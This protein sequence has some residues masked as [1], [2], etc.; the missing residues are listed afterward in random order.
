MASGRRRDRR[1]GGTQAVDD[2]ANGARFV[3]WP[4]AA[5][6]E[7]D[8]RGAMPWTSARMLW[9]LLVP[10]LVLLGLLAWWGIA[11]IEGQIET[12]APA[13]LEDRGIDSSSLTFSAEYRDLDVG[14]TLPRGVVG[15]DIERILEEAEGSG[16]E[17]IRSVT[18]SAVR[19][20]EPLG[21]INVAVTSDGSTIVLTGNVPSD[22]HRDALVAAATGTGLTVI[23]NLAV[24][25][26]R[27]SAEA[28]EDQVAAME[29]IVAVLDTDVESADLSVGDSGPVIGSVRAVDGATEDELRRL[30]P[31]VAVSSPDPLGNLDV[32]ATFDGSRIVL[33]GTV[34]N[35]QHADS[36]L[37]GAA[38]AVGRPSV[39]DNLTVLGLAPAV[40][41]PE[42]KVS[43]MAAILA[44][45]EG[46]ETGEIAL[47]DTD[48]TVNAAVADAALGDRIADAVADSTNIGLR[49]GGEVS[50]I[51][52]ELSLQEEIDALQAELDAL[53]DEIRKNVVFT[54]SSNSLSELASGTLDKVVDA[55]DRYQRPVVEVG[56][57]TDSRGTDSF[58][59]SLSQR[60]AEAVVNY[61]IS[62]GMAAERLNPVG[63]GESDPV[64]PDESEEAY[65]LNRRVE[66]T[67][68]ESF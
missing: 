35:Q 37:A 41:D 56:G 24:S 22:Q 66:F 64:T 9:T 27:A 61:L 55:M 19:F 39:V 12:T 46:A 32:L 34:L 3:S 33:D 2:A 57:H 62:Q 18:V 11:H 28:P 30:G 1:A 51:E 59:L 17:D 65:Q 13:L 45:F 8:G 10:L 5:L 42:V 23:D 25:G 14:G 7:G 49:P 48:L 29:R 16:G 60:R 53:Q 20:E 38:S 52:P 4:R 26:L 40:P 15:G 31:S 47:T 50:V 67:A 68:L 58:N 63:Y 54:R 21:P 36:L 43:T 44:L 6:V